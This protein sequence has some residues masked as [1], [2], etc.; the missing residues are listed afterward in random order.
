MR[1]RSPV[2]RSSATSVP[3]GAAQAAYTRPTGFS[4]VPREPVAGAILQ[5]NE[6]KEKGA[7][8]ISADINSGMNGDTGEAEIA[9][10]S[11]LTVSI[12]YLKHGLLQGKAKELIGRLVNVEIGI[13]L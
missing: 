13:E 2:R 3:S 5:V 11:N 8:V 4:G 10:K 12:G 7:F 6:A 9:V 1:C